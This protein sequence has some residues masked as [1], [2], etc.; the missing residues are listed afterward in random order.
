MFTTLKML[1]GGIFLAIFSLAVAHQAGAQ[2]MPDVIEIDSLSHLYEGVTFDHSMHVDLAE[3]CSVCHHQNAGVPVQD[4][5]CAGCHAGTTKSHIVSCG[6]CHPV[7][8]FSAEYLRQKEADVKRYHRDKPG[9]KA[10]YHQN[11]MGCHD[12][13]DGPTGC[14]DCHARTEAGDKLF[15]AGDFAP[16]PGVAQSGHH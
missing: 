6:Q 14:Q 1:S 8:P 5:N 3:N 11:C 4:Q 12:D 10:A 16:Q 9:L 2:E 15:H 13:M 7:E